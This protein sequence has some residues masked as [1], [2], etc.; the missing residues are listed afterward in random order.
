MFNQNTSYRQM[1]IYIFPNHLLQ[2]YTILQKMTA[3]EN[4]IAQIIFAQLRCRHPVTVVHKDS[5]LESCLKS[6]CT[7]RNIMIKWCFQQSPQ[8]IVTMV[9][10]SLYKALVAWGY[11]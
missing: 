6:S 3:G 10:D 7:H 4:H 8:G 1:V 11:A 5:H 9:N 2:R